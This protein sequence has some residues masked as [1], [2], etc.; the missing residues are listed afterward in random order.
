MPLYNA[1]YAQSG[2][3]TAVINATACGLIQTAR[4]HHD[5][6]NKMYAARNGIIGALTEDLIDTSFESDADIAA[7]RYTPAGAFGSCRHKLGTAEKNLAQYERLIQV[8]SA[9][10]IRYFFYNG[11]G[12]SQDTAYKIS[13]I[14]RTLGYPI[15]CI[16]IP[17]TIDN[18][19]PFTDNSPGFG[20]V[21][22]YVAVSI[23]EA[24]LDVASMA[25]TSTKVFILE[26]M[27]RHTGWI[28]AAS[29][30][31]HERE[32]DAPHIILF[33]EILF[34]PDIFLERVK[35]CVK[36]FGSCS[37]V[38]SEGLR[39]KDGAFIAE[40]GLVDSFGHKQLGGVAPVLAR[41]IKE[42]C[43]FK[44][45]WA[46]A[47]YLQRSARH[48]ASKTDVEQAY[49]LGVAAIQLALSEKN[50]VMPIIVRDTNLPY[51]WSIGEAPL[52]KVANVEVHLP[53]DFISDDGFGITKKCR[54][55]LTPLIEGED[56][57]P[58]H[59]GLPSY[60]QLKNKAVEKKLRHVDIS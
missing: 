36:Q 52:E 19:L 37:I 46:L 8:F 13:Q 38:V 48:I 34:D 39:N 33:P 49:A 27:G 9:H 41:L 45:H 25:E 35:Q 2:G 16:G 47:D 57:P 5:K 20:S 4:I 58:Y 21:A 53:R 23:R 24:G 32:S 50:A 60:V 59:H 40:S 15:I 26:V 51:S 44:Y 29:G 43:G 28:A 55:Y 17:K 1:L 10:D 11:G 56:Y 31:A 12:D 30:L 42:K 18:D 3:V 7:L 6:I 54:D 14:S 22:K